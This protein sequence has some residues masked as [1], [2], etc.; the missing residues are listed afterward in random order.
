MNIKRLLFPPKCVFCS[1]ILTEDEQHICTS[2]AEEL[3][4]QKPPSKRSGAFFDAA[5]SFLTYSGTVRRAIH[6][7][8]YYGKIH[9][10]NYFAS[11]MAIRYGR[12]EKTLPDIITAVPSHR[13][14]A[15]KRGFDHS[16]LL[17]QKVGERLGIEPSRLLK[18]L[19][20]TPAMYGLKA[21]QRR[22]NI[23][24]SI[25]FMGDAEQIK[26]KHILLIDDIF[27]TGSTAAECARVLKT[28]GA[29]RVTVLV[30]AMTVKKK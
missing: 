16:F 26:G 1:R 14:K 22:A 6:R 15:A 19:E 12:E 7:Y 24:G 20:A 11:L 29:K 10:A 17:A 21:E 13:R 4:K 28:F 5:Y 23:R 2:C 9:Y 3:R 8:K 25:G 30:A 27:T 18:K